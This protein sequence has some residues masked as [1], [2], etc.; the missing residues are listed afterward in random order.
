VADPYDLQRFIAAQQGTFE[1]A[2]QEISSGSK[3]GHWMWFIFPQLA[4]LGHSS[5][6]RFYGIASLDE[7]RAYLEDPVLGQRLRQCVEALTAWRGKRS[8][9]QVLGPIDAI[10]LRSCLT[11]FDRVEPEG[12][13]RAALSALFGGKPDELTLAL[14]NDAR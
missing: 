9:E 13:F 11:L 4:G 14:L 1:T 3:R 8:A 7:A 5:T 2:L 6:A 10:K 12:P